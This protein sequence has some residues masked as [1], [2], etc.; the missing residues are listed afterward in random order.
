[1]QGVSGMTKEEL[2]GALEKAKIPFEE[3]QTQDFETEVETLRSL[4][5]SEV[6]VL[7]Q[8]LGNDWYAFSEVQDEIYYGVIGQDPEGYDPYGNSEA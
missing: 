4:V 5:G 6:E 8:T 2:M 7:Y 1:M 3:V